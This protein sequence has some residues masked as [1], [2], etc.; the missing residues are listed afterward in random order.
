MTT[1]THTDAHVHTD[2]HSHMQTRAHRHT[3]THVHTDTHAHTVVLTHRHDTTLHRCSTNLWL[4]KS[5]AK[6]LL[7]TTSYQTGAIMCY[8][9]LTAQHH[10]MVAVIHIILSK[11]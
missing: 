8:L 9:Q 2:T 6:Q 3:L 1:D 10:M 4:A 7:Q 11:L 5:Q